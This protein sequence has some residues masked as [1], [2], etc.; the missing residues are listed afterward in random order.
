MHL[1]ETIMINRSVAEVW[2]FLQQPHSESIWHPAIVED[3]ITS[4]G[5]LRVGS[6]GIQVF[7]LLRRRVQSPWEIT[8]FEQQRKVTTRSTGGPTTWKGTYLLEPVG[9]ATRFTVDIHEELPGV[10]RLLAPLFDRVTRKQW[11]SD[12]AL[13]KQVVE[14]QPVP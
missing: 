13:L 7:N 9:T 8:E 1:R 12:L 11:L 10:A 6:T 14:S 3:R 5:E 2:T 4:E